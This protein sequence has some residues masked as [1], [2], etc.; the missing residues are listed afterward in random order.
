MI[1]KSNWDKFAKQQP[2]AMLMVKKLAKERYEFTGSID[3][4]SE[5]QRKRF[6]L[7]RQ[8]IDEN[9][10]LYGTDTYSEDL[11]TIINAP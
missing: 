9:G 6:S 4:A 11:K 5:E 10:L 2:Y 8:I 7:L 3:L 1:N